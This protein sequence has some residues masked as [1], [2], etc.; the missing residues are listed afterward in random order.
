MQENNVAA[1]D[2]LKGQL[3]NQLEEK[4]NMQNEL[5]GIIR[6]LVKFY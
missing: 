3:A 5:Y 2:N 1:M 4:S 6:K